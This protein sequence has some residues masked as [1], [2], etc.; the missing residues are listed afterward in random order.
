LSENIKNISPKLRFKEFNNIWS[1]K[2]ISEL[3]TIGSGKDYKHL[4]KGD[5]PVYGTG[6]LMNFV[7]D[8]LHDGESIC[9]GR[10]GTI[11]KPRYLNGKFWTVDTLFYTH[12]FKEVYPKFVFALFQNINWYKY[13]E[14]SGV[15]SLSKATIEK[16][17]LAIPH[18]IEQK[19]IAS[20]LSA[21]DEKLQKLSKKKELLEEYKKGVIQKI[22]SQEIRFKDDNGNY[23]QKWE[24]KNFDDIFSLIS[25]EEINIK[26]IKENGM[27]K[28]VEQGKEKKYRFSNN[29]KKLIKNETLIVYGDHTTEVKFIDF[30]FIAGPSLKFLKCSELHNLKFMFYNLIF[31]NIKPEGYKRHFSILKKISLELPLKEEQKKIADFLSSI[32]KKIEFVSHQLEKTKEFKKGLLQQMFV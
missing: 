21:V 16:I 19:K 24:V 25:H 15:P 8:F 10:K 2:K 14:A 22:F 6:G 32:D 27:Y 23:F 26:E 3:L 12:G 29:E 20:F 28:V 17:N 11:N 1:E 31:N 18:K 7:D 5:V 13:N 9:I 4:N 30:D